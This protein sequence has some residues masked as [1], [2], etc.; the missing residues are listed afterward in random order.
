LQKG[1][2]SC[3][4]HINNVVLRISKHLNDRVFPFLYVR[5]H[6]RRVYECFQQGLDSGRI[7]LKMRSI[8][9]IILLIGLLVTDSGDIISGRHCSDYRKKRQGEKLKG[10]L[11]L[12][13]IEESLETSLCSF[14]INHRACNFV[15]LQSWWSLVAASMRPCH[16]LRSVICSVSLDPTVDYYY[17]KRSFPCVARTFKIVTST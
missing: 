9:R 2:G 4:S 10:I 12:D 7:G 14:V 15:N 6:F 11:L 17:L 1:I 5:F 13:I 8:T 16:Q 3:H